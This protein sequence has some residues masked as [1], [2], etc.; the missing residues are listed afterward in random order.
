M[1][2]SRPRDRGGTVAAVVLAGGA[3]RRMGRDK[4]VLE[5]DGERLV[6]LV[7]DRLASVVDQVVVAS[8][9]R[10]LGRDDEVADAPDT[11]G[12][13][14]GLVAGLRAAS[15]SVVVVVPVDAPRTGPE[16]LLRLARVCLE[17]DRSAAV[18]VADGHVQA[19]HAA[20]HREALP[21]IESR[22][23]AGEWSPRRLLGWLDAVRLDH[24]GW[25]DLDPTGGFARDWDRPA[26][27]P[28]GVRGPAGP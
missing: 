17:L 12:P 28:P 14:A 9:S 18:A 7:A 2:G 15:A 26:D 25:A 11:S 22:V 21:A 3:S 1:N 5:V 13:L 20:F 27:L 10:P 16:L 23:A 24:D 4:A 6:D 8:G 19:L